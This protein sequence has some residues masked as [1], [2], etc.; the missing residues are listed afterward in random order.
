MT[1]GGR[2]G[3]R[4][5][6]ATIILGLLI[7]NM[8]LV[9]PGFTGEY[10]QYLGSIEAGYISGTRFIVDHFPH[11]SWNPLWYLGYPFHLFYT[12]FL[13]YLIA[14]INTFTPAIS[15]GSA[16]RLVTGFLYVLGPVTLFLFVRQLTRREFTAFVAAVSYS[17]LPSVAYLIGEVRSVAS[18]FGCAPWRL[19][20][21]ILFGEGPHNS[22]LAF[23]PLAALFFLRLL[24]KPCLGNYILTAITISLVAL[25]DLAALYG[26]AVILAVILLGEI[27][28]GDALKKLATAFYGALL[29]Y[30]L[31]AFWYNLSFIRA[32]FAYIAAGG[33][34]L[35]L[36]TLPP[37]L[38]IGLPI[39]GGILLALS[40]REK[41][42]PLLV[43]IPWFLIFSV[44]E[45]GWYYL[46]ISLSPQ[47]NRYIPELDMAFCMLLAIAVTQAMDR[48]GARGLAS[49]LAR[50][51]WGT[52]VVALLIFVS[53][54]F[55]RQAWQITSPNPEIEE[56]SEYRI[57][58][59]LEEQI[60]E[61]RVYVTGTNAFWLN[62]FTQVPQLR[63]GMDQGATNPWWA[64][65]AYQIN[66][67]ED[68]ELAVLWAR[69]LG[70]KY[71][72]VNYPDSTV[73]YKDY[74]HPAKFEGLLPEAYRERGDVIF[75][76]PN[77]HTELLRV[78]D[79]EEI[80]SLSPIQDA[81]DVE[82][83][84]A[85]AS[86]VDEELPR[87][88]VDYTWENNDHLIIQAR[89]EEGA[90]LL[91][92]MTYDSGWRAF[93]DGQRVEIK[94]DPL[95]F[96]VIKP[97]E[98]GEYLIHL[99]HG[100]VWDEWLGYGVTLATLAFVSFR[101]VVSRRASKGIVSSG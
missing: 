77:S 39:V 25:I 43:V 36:G 58:K 101:V 3:S 90:A 10:T 81:L 17:L 93:I 71:I 95:S 23:T 87:S 52:V 62:V 21:L 6:T 20:V 89:L 74:Q 56:T 63:G 15:I 50:P 18:G 55:L 70:I 72:V 19:V 73:E 2:T 32:P 66:K 59:F 98:P 49:A 1:A 84:R 4:I 54:P 12:P 94:P 83:L 100:R 5:K 79:A 35:T 80:K 33:G 91:V 57:A 44:I 67:G 27:M 99:Q 48:L 96:M 24:K 28:A 51:F 86:L 45:I 75:E 13:P 78:V 61:E 69:A 46:G 65:V 38:V 11:L 14:A 26:L 97:D 7:L 82:N 16:Y 9:F 34:N 29:T 22:G 92:R 85:Y 76:V 8:A 41:S 88:T 30:G 37:L 40:G 31:C 42:Q 68:G 60:A 47:P 53:L 64:H